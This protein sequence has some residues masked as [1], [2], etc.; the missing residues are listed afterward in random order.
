MGK[1]KTF[2]ERLRKLSAAPRW[3]PAQARWI[4]DELGRSALTVAEFTSKYE[5]SAS[6]LYYWRK[7]LGVLP[8][9]SEPK[10]GLVEVRLPTR[11]DVPSRIEIELVGGRR[12]CVAGV[13]EPRRLQRLVM[14]LEG[15]SC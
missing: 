7:R 2:T 5:F 8:T 3:S 1:T 13:I 15:Q 10:A 9:E 4:I 11:D 14:A 6:R 12:L